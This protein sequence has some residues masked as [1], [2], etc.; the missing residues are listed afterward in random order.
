MATSPTLTLPE[1]L[2][3]TILKLDNQE[4]KF[5]AKMELT[6]IV[7]DLMPG[8]VPKFLEVVKYPKVSDLA[9]QNK[10]RTLLLISIMVRDFCSSL[11]V[12]RNM[13]EDQIIEAAGMLMDE[14]DNMRLEDYT[15]M[16]ALAKRGGLVKI[17]DRIDLQVISDIFDA[18]WIKRSNAAIKAEEEAVN[19]QETQMPMMRTS[20]PDDFDKIGS[21]GSA[22]TEMKN[23]LQDKL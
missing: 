7:S 15:M 19:S 14:S 11:N 17:Y 22:L 8:G 18:Y 21:L 16:F 1:R 13:N 20:K 5:M 2:Q 9:I 23:A 6:E 12:V 3:N 10:P 4:N